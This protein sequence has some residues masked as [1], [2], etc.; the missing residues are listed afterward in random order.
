V[1][2]KVDQQEHLHENLM[3][4]RKGDQKEEVDPYS[5]QGV[6]AHRPLELEVALAVDCRLVEASAD[7]RTAVVTVGVLELGHTLEM[8]ERKE[9]L[10][11]KRVVVKVAQALQL[12]VPEALGASLFLAL[13]LQ[14]GL[15]TC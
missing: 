12:E 5:Q 4:A 2:L 3:E 9:E 10:V 7:A 6:V 15:V 8:V 1:G 13:C 11:R 14:V